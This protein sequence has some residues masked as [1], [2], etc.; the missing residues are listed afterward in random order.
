AQTDAVSVAELDRVAR[1]AQSNGAERQRAWARQDGLVELMTTLTERFARP[2][3]R[4]RL[5]SARS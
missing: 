2:T 3:E 5:N 1:L 4:S